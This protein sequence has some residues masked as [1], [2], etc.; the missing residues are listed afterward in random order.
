MTRAFRK[1]DREGIAIRYQAWDENQDMVRDPS[2]FRMVKEHRETLADLL[3][4]DRLQLH[5]RTERGWAPPPKG[6]AEKSEQ[7]A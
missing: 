4:T 5:D 2:F 6:Y 3:A 7:D 1:H